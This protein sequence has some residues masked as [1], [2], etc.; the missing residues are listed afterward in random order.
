MCYVLYVM[1]YGQ[2]SYFH[3][4]SPM[5]Y[6]PYT[7]KDSREVESIGIPTPAQGMG[8]LSSNGLCTLYHVLCTVYYILCITPS[9]LCIMYYALCIMHY[10]PCSMCS[11]LCVMYYVLCIIYYAQRTIVFALCIKHSVLSTTYY[12]FWNMDNV[13]IFKD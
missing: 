1:A 6:V 2:C 3:G 12:M 10:T 11:V 9:V 5:Y 8:I 4:L 13:Y 7:S